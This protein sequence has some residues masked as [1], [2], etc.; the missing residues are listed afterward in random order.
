MGY[1]FSGFFSEMDNERDRALKNR[2]RQSSA[3]RQSRL[4]QEKVDQDKFERAKA[5]EF[6]G[7]EE[8]SRRMAEKHRSQTNLADAQA[9]FARERYPGGPAERG[10]TGIPAKIKALGEIQS[11]FEQTRMDRR[12]WYDFGKPNKEYLN[13][14]EIFMEK[15]A[16]SSRD[17][18]LGLGGQPQPSWKKYQK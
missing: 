16:K 13:E 11:E 14:D 15:Q 18:I 10:E 12:P 6:A 2:E 3:T 1:D 17:R 5:T 8:F 7:P 9:G 4:D